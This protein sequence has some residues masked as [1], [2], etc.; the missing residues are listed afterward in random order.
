LFAAYTQW[1]IENALRQMTSTKFAWELKRL[2]IE[3]DDGKRFW[4]GIC[5]EHNSNA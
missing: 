4:Y 2:G 3:G 1:S 5:I